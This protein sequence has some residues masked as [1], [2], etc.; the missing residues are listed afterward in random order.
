VI[1]LNLP[2]GDNFGW[3]VCGKYI[4]RELANLA[5]VR[6]LTTMLNPKQV[7]DEFE[8]LRLGQLL[9]TDQTA[10][11]D[12]GNWPLLQ[13]ITGAA[14]TPLQA[15]L[16]G[17]RTIGYTFFED[18]RL[19]PAAIDGARKHFDL[20]A[21][22]SSWCTNVLHQ[23]G[24]ADAVTVIQGIDPSFFFPREPETKLFPDHFLVFSGGKFELRKGQDLV[25]RAFKVLHDR[26]PDVLLV[27]AWYN[28]WAFSWQTMKGSPYIHFAPRSDQYFD[29]LNQ[30]YAD[31]GIDAKRTIN[32]APR[33]NQTFSTIYRNT[34][35]GIFPNRCEGGTNLVLME[36]MACERPVIATNSTGHADIV[37]SD[38]ALVISSP[39]TKS[40][41]NPDGSI[42]ADWPEPDLEQTIALLEHAYQNR[43]QTKT[44]AKRAAEDMAKLT[45]AKTAQ[46]FL[47][48]LT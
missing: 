23:H 22:G 5:P 44:L 7:V 8:I 37:R 47:N 30:I 41:Q 26:H 25:L 12:V 35:V 43:D 28:Q 31:N 11:A 17:R 36:Y 48:L 10:I 21:T 29:A 40:I 19:T 24:L 16:K 27:T 34:D 4:A 32:L 3:G 18:S 15:E 13:A 14:L 42:V 9:P 33:S 20:L 2:V 45:W 38:N 6:L 46:E 1:Y 39:T